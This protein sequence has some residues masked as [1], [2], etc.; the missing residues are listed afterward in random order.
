MQE[1]ENWGSQLIFV[2]T[3]AVLYRVVADIELANGAPSRTALLQP[4]VTAGKVTHQHLAGIAKPF[5]LTSQLTGL[6]LSHE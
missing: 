6:R 5:A 2:P 3:V 4:G 1:K